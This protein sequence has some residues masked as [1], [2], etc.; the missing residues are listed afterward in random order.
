MRCENP[1]EVG[2]S[3]LKGGP[4]RLEAK[5]DRRPWAPTLPDFPRLKE[6]K[7]RRLGT[8]KDH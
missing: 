6:G 3:L 1:A 2:H 7:E 5:V 4:P 8:F